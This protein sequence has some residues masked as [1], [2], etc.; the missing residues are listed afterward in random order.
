LVAQVSSLQVDWWVR[1]QVQAL[2][3]SRVRRLLAAYDY[4]PG[5]QE[6]VIGRVLKQ[7][8]ALRR[9][10]SRSRVEDLGSVIRVGRV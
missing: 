5:G 1:E 2:V 10:T 7:T 3:R 9:R 6:D 4:P 8:R